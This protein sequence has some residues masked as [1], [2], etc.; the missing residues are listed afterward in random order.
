M[1][2]D[3]TVAYRAVRPAVHTVGRPGSA[4]H[5]KADTRTT[6][7]V[8]RQ[9]SL[10]HQRCVHSPVDVTL[11][12]SAACPRLYTPKTVAQ[13]E[14]PLSARRSVATNEGQQSSDLNTAP[15]LIGAV[16]GT[17]VGIPLSP[18]S[19]KVT[20]LG[21][22]MARSRMNARE[23]PWARENNAMRGNSWARPWNVFSPSAQPRP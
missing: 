6:G 7:L 21:D 3:Y 4:A 23:K 19:P 22:L 9:G 14:V 16:R 11:I 10:L 8:R 15:I 1:Q 17:A 13:T 18:K 20:P 12:R 5:L 2:H